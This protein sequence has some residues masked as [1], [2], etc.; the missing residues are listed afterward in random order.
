MNTSQT[1]PN[2]PF[3]F[4]LPRVGERDPHFGLPRSMY[5]KLEEEDRIKLI[6]L[7]EKN[8]RRGTTLVPF[9]DVMA[10]LEEAR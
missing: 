7:R 4:R 8:K 3:A 1:S 10:V 5:Y 9:A 6:R 2:H